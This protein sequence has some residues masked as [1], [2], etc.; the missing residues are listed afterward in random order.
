MM[1]LKDRGGEASPY[2]SLI[3]VPGHGAL[4]S[5]ALDRIA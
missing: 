2:F 4:P 3:I 1:P 5:Q